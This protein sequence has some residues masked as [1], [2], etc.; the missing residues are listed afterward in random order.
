[1]CG[2]GSDNSEAEEQRRRENERQALITKGNEAID[3]TFGQF[4]DAFYADRRDSYLNY[5]KP[6]LDDQLSAA[7]KDLL[8][9][10][11]RSGMSNSSVAANK[12]EELQK[13]ADMRERE[14]MDKG[15]NYENS[16]RKSIQSAKDD[17]RTQN[18]QMAN[19]TLAAN[20]AIARAQTL[21]TLPE[22]S[23]LGALFEGITSGLATQAD[24]ERRGQ[25]KYGNILFG[26]NDSSKVVK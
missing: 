26:N 5:A 12:R 2:G 7:T 14:I 24:L 6:Q 23:P 16:A 1:M 9:V 19:P 17:L 4:D 22:Y 18:M 21:T 20:N 3:K 11:S 15:I 25:A 13:M 10:L 8:T